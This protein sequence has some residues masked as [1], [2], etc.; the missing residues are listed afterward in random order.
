MVKKMKKTRLL[1]LLI[2]TAFIGSQFAYAEDRDPTRLPDAQ[3]T[4]EEATARIQVW[5]SKVSGLEDE[6]AKLDAD[7][8]QLKADLDK[9]NKD[10]EDCNAALYALIGATPQDVEAFR[11]KLGQLEGKVRDMKRWSDDK[12]ADNQDKVLA[13][14]EELNQMRQVK[15]SLLPD[16]YNKILATARDIRGLYREKKITTY[17]VG[18]WSEDRDCLWNIAGK[19]DIYGDPFMWP[20]IW[21][22]NTEIVRNPDI[23]HPGQVLQLPPPAPKTSDEMKAER[24]Y[25]R[26][27]KETMEEETSAVKGQ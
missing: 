18:T 12:L 22:A 17:T 27:K 10:L 23:I 9:T 15:I 16:I 19:I 5:E 13:L 21:Q 14:E 11:Q 3:L 26:E 7:I 25:W 2:I 24:R 1:L 6:L 4:K 8:A 20:K